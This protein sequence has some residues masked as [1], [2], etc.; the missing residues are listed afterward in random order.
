MIASKGLS[1]MV[2]GS[3]RV[4]PPD[5]HTTRIMPWHFVDKDDKKWLVL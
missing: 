3:E 5:Y 4:T 2:M 1:N